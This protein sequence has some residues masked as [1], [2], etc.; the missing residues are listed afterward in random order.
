MIAK[1]TS[2]ENKLVS[3]PDEQIFRL[4]FEGHS[5]AMLLIEF[6]TGIILN[7]NQAA[8]DFYGYPKSKLCSM[9]IN[10]INVLS[11]EHMTTKRE[12]ALNEKWDYFV[13]SHRLASGEVHSS[14]IALQKKEV[15]FS[16]IRDI[17]ERV[18]TSIGAM[19]IETDN[20]SLTLSISIGIAQTIHNTAQPDSAQNLLLRAD[21]SLYA[22]KQNRRN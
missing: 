17:T 6:K 22:A 10:E 15:L 20:G 5:M 21:Q 9:S 11:P 4:M 3:A 2:W 1:K 8:V 13:F 19:G 16:I 18:H 14:L 12:K 7:V